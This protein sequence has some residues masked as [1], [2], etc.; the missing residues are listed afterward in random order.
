M[1]GLRKR[2]AASSY[3]H[4]ASKAHQA[5]GLREHGKKKWSPGL[6]DLEDI[7]VLSWKLKRVPLLVIGLYL[8]SSIGLGGNNIRK[9]GELASIVKDRGDLGLQLAIGTT[10]H[11]SSSKTAGSRSSRRGSGSPRIQG[12]RARQDLGA[13]SITSFALIQPLG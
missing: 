11:G 5:I 4:L 1:M 2:Y 3:R 7:T 6:L 13:S 8:D 9:L 12:T 10:S